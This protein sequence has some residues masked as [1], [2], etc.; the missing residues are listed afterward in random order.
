MD[1][2]RTI[3]SVHDD[4]TTQ[5]FHTSPFPHIHDNATIRLQSSKL[6]PPHVKFNRIHTQAINHP[7]SLNPS[8]CTKQFAQTPPTPI[9]P[10]PPRIDINSPSASYPSHSQY[11]PPLPSHIIDPPRTTTNIN[12]HPP[13]HHVNTSS[14]SH[15]HNNPVQQNQ[16][17]EISPSYDII[18]KTHT[19][20]ITHPTS[21]K[22]SRCTKKFVQ[23]TPTSIPP[24]PL[25]I[26]KN[27][28]SASY[29]SH[30]QYISPI[31]PHIM[32][33]TRTINSVHDDVNTQHLN[34]SPFPHIHNNS[35][36][37]HQSPS[38]SPS[39]V[40]IDKIPTQ[41]IPHPTS[42]NSTRCTKQSTQPTPT[43]N[44]SIHSCIDINSSS[45]SYPSHSQYNPPPSIQKQYSVHDY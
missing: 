42:S 22:P 2:S 9:L 6:S 7:T 37:Q 11:N 20:T 21:P 5:H 40:N 23:P 31:P 1:T 39:P 10:V 18:T 44:L 24:I 12:N 3:N 16:S 45:A 26:K 13:T 17:S 19:H 28:P 30:N 38:S 15:I 33:T 14:T 25:R 34:T 32:D 4:T 8:S 43:S 29:P 36:I 41:A 27:S 35:A